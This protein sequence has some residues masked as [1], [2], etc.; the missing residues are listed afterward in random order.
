MVEVAE[1][2]ESTNREPMRLHHRLIHY[3]FAFVVVVVGGTVPPEPRY[4]PSSGPQSTGATA[5]LN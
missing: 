5:E 1:Q 4:P 3:W 2:Q